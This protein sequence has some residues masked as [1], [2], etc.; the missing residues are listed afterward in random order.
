MQVGNK[1]LARLE[2]TFISQPNLC[3]AETKKLTVD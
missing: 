2:T 3:K 1:K